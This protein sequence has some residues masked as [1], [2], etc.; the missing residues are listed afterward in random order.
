MTAPALRLWTG[1]TVHHRYAPFERRFAYD[2][3]LID[4]D[5]DRLTEAGRQ[6]WLFSIERPG[7]FSFLPEDHGEKRKGAPLRPWAEEMFRKAGVELAG[8][9]IRL[10]T[11]PRHLFYKFAP[12]SLWYGYGVDGALR[13]I[14]YEVNNTFG[15]R[16]CY[17]AATGPERSEHEA[18]KTFHVSPFMDV[19]GQYRFTLRAPGGNLRVTVE[20]W[21]NG[22]RSHMANINAVELPATTGNLARL[23]LQQPFSSFGV[24]AGIHWQA[25]KIWIKGAGYR[26]KPEAPSRAATIATS[27][28]AKTPL[29]SEE[30]V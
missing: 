7:V 1:K 24:T 15:E 28:P 9:V 25:L 27:I 17:V 11:F 19:S 10:V 23:A 16:H 12:L 4:L 8:G 18:E 21:I 14:I 30:P 22:A 20:N 26:R 2:I 6:S 5:I 3:A 29:R 13:G